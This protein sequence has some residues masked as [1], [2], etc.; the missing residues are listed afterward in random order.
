MI[1]YG[2]IIGCCALGLCLLEGLQRVANAI[3][4]CFP[5]NVELR[6]PHTIKVVQVSA[7][8]SESER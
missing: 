5:K 7:G 2:I 4:E 1:G 3:R 8:E 6:F